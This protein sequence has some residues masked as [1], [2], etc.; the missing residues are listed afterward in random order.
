MFPMRCELDSYMSF[1][2]N[3]VCKFNF[4]RGLECDC[5]SIDL[6]FCLLLAEQDNDSHNSKSTLRI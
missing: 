1:I 6:V 2:R 3:S 5:S 4:T